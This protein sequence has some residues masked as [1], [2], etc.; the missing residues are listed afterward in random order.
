M[1]N[2]TYGKKTTKLGWVQCANPC[3]SN[4]HKLP[5]H[6]LGELV[7]EVGG[8]GVKTLAETQLQATL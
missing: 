6:E 1:K 7:T 8:F 2:S 5:M 4:W 3:A